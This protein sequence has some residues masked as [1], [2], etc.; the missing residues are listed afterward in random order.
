MTTKTIKTFPNVPV[1]E[2]FLQEWK[3]RA[4]EWYTDIVKQYFS[5]LRESLELRNKSNDYDLSKDER[6]EFKT[7]FKVHYDDFKN[8]EKN[9]S[10]IEKNIIVGRSEKDAHECIEKHIEREVKAK[11]EILFTRIQK[12]AG[13]ILEAYLYI[14]VNGEINGH[15]KGDIATVNVNT[16]YA[17]GHN[18]QCL[19]YRV[20]VK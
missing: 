17:G 4:N 12:K 19:H 5:K 11:R 20:L 14:G 6:E 18:I 9:L 16:I 2:E 15:I 1:I 3:T 13:N 7:Q 8:W 10:G